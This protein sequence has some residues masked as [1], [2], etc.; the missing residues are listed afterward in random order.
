MKQ[1]ESPITGTVTTLADFFW[2]FMTPSIIKEADTDFKGPHVLVIL[3]ILD[4]FGHLM[5]S[6][7]IWVTHVPHKTT[8]KLTSLAS[9]LH[10]N[11]IQHICQFHPTKVIHRQT[12]HSVYSAVNMRFLSTP[13]SRAPGS[14]HQT[15]CRPLLRVPERPAVLSVSL[16][17]TPSLR[18]LTSD[19]RSQ[20][21]D[22]L[23]PS[24]WAVQSEFNCWRDILVVFFSFMNGYHCHSVTTL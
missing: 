7:Y 1:W 16:S 19:S 9:R 18:G 6:A 4:Y 8:C 12:K 13:S 21:W 3:K 17:L 11:N 10:S 14:C 22:P 15:G 5:Q 23:W 20:R 24:V 2:S